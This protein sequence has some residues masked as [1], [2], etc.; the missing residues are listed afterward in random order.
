MNDAQ[1]LKQLND[2]ER[3]LADLIIKVQA[4]QKVQ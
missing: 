2:I 3:R 4:M 1:R